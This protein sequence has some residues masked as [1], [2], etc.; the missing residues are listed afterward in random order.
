MEGGAQY[1]QGNETAVVEGAV[2]LM[3]AAGALGWQKHGSLEALPLLVQ[4]F[5]ALPRRTL[6]SKIVPCLRPYLSGTVLDGT[7]LVKRNGN[8]HKNA[9]VEPSILYIVLSLEALGVPV[10]STSSAPA[11]SSSVTTTSNGAAGLL[12]KQSDVALIKDT[13]LKSM[14]PG[15]DQKIHPVWTLVIDAI[16]RA[17]VA[18]SHKGGIGKSKVP[19]ESG[20]TNREKEG[21]GS[22]G[23]GDE[24]GVVKSVLQSLWTTVIVNLSPALQLQVGRESWRKLPPTNLGIALPLPLIR[25]LSHELFSYSAMSSRAGKSKGGGGISDGGKGDK[26]GAGRKRDNRAEEGGGG[27]MA[28]EAAGELITCVEDRVRRGDLEAADCAR[29]LRAI[30]YECP[31]WDSR[32]KGGQGGGGKKKRGGG[33]GGGVVEALVNRLAAR[34]VRRHMLRL[35]GMYVDPWV[36]ADA[37]SES[38][39]EDSKAREGKRADKKRKTSPNAE[40]KHK[41]GCV[42]GSKEFDL[43][44]RNSQKSACYYNVRSK[45]T[46]ELTFEN[47]CQMRGA[48]LLSMALSLFVLLCSW[49]LIIRTG[50]LRILRR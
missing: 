14:W 27:G 22:G 37:E 38:R 45:V 20:S 2:R 23:D 34:E 30:T 21:G 15:N 3:S 4:L 28:R 32:I 49:Q 5:Q 7:S 6:V 50:I 10:S 13:L 31:D 41:K 35:A 29:I 1:L 26:D 47:L 12:G 40:D 17:G 24:G 42:P 18:A 36:T 9:A 8:A 44:G 25:L 19:G 43:A 48:E 11:S 39:D 33:S 16:S 46:T